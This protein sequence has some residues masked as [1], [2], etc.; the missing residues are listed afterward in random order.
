LIAYSTYAAAQE[1]SGLYL[2]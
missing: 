2:A 1:A